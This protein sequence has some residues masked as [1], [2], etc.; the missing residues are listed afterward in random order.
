MRFTTEPEIEISY[1]KIVEINDE[2]S[3]DSLFVAN[4]AIFFFGTERLKRMS[5]T[6]KPTPRFINLQNPDGSLMYPAREQI[7][8]KIFKFI[9]GNFCLLSIV[10]IVYYR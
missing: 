7:D 5:C 9:H 3:T 2:S 6:G 10:L 4:L 8:P 1:E